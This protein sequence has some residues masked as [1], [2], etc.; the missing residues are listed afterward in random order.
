M[1]MV[2]ANS[3]VL[4]RELVLAD[5]QTLRLFDLRTLS[6]MLLWLGVP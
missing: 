6:D 4:L 1:S 5:L 2:L 3:C